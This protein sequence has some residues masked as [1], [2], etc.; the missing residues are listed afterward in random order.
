MGMNDLA[1]SLAMRDNFIQIAEATVEKARPRYRY[2]TVNSIDLAA[3]KC[4]VTFNGDLAPVQV[5]IG[6]V[7]P[8]ALGQVVRV[9]GIGTDKYIA[10]V[11]GDA[12]GQNLENGAFRG[13]IEPN[14]TVG[15]PKVTIE[16]VNTLHPWVTRWDGNSYTPKSG[17]YVVAI[18]MRNKAL[19]IMPIYISSAE[20]VI[21]NFTNL[22]LMN[23]WA[24]YGPGY[25]A[26]SYTKTKD[27]IVVLRGLLNSTTAAAMV[28]GTTIAVLPVGFR[29]SAKMIFTT[30]YRDTPARI[31][32]F[33]NGEVRFLTP[34]GA[35]LGWLSLSGIAFP[36][37]GTWTEPAL[38]SS[39][40]PYSVAGDANGWPTAGFMVDSS[41]TVWNRG[42]LK[43]AANPSGDTLILSMGTENQPDAQVHELSGISGGMSTITV[44][45]QA[46]GG[47]GMPGDLV[48]PGTGGAYAAFLSLDNLAHVKKGVTNWVLAT[49]SSNWTPYGSPYPSARAYKRPDGL[50]MLQGLLRTTGG[51]GMIGTLPVGYRPKSDLV[52]AAT[53][54][55]ARARIDITSAGQIGLINAD[56]PNGWYSLDSISFIAEQ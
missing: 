5:N 7:A 20:V 11:M 31:D 38:L 46:T 1:F 16:G 40:L 27:G 49:L 37:Q 44:R 3:R 42:L 52:F 28:G 51:S 47:T 17:D 36:T 6:S 18:P 30:L 9:E 8:S 39:W 4:N 26:A 29:P 10:D 32:V 33:P 19:W 41:G 50:V 48:W 14:F 24:Q 13:W 22:T 55:G 21:P 54:N 35:A 34:A 53:A 23:G 45:A 43:R 56:V 12:Y 15:N 25:A 2:A